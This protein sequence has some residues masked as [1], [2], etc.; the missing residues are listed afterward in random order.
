MKITLIT[1]GILSFGLAC[2]MIGTYEERLDQDKR[3]VC[4]KKCSAN[5]LNYSCPDECD[6]YLA[7]Q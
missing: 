1:L 5:F 4:L 6:E 7:D 3:Q 2:F